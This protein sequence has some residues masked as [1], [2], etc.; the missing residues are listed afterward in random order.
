MGFNSHPAP[1]YQI[2]QLE[3][4]MTA[5]DMTAA[6]GMDTAMAH[7][8]GMTDIACVVGSHTLLIG[9]PELHETA[10]AYNCL[11]YAN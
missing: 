4:Y 10:V 1:R 6:V 5:A 3:V 7:T 9:A 8:P 2:F 11:L